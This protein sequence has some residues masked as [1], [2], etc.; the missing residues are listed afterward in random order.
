AVD[1]L[2]SVGTLTAFMLY[3]RQFFDPLQELSQFYNSLQAANAGLE[4]IAAVLATE[5]TVAD[6]PEAPELA[7]TGGEV[8]LEGVT[9]AYRDTAVLHAVDLTVEPGETLAL[10]GATGAGKST[11]AKLIAR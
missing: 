9:F 10:V 4:K 8:R 3:L 1:G 5:S 7:A 2:V 6:R 11:I